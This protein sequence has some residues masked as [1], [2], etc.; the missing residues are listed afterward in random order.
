MNRRRRVFTS[1]LADLPLA[2]KQPQAIRYAL[3]QSLFQILAPG[4]RLEAIP[5]Y[6]RHHS[7]TGCT[8][9]ASEPAGKIA[10]I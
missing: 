7:A 3:L 9:A 8:P 2:R 10:G 6:V 5:E 1:E 4:M